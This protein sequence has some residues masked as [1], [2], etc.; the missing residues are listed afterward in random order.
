MEEMNHMSIRKKRKRLYQ[1]TRKIIPVLAVCGA[2]ILPLLSFATE[3]FDK[4]IELRATTVA[5][6]EITAIEVGDSILIEV[7]VASTNDDELTEPFV[8]NTDQAEFILHL[9]DSFTYNEELTKQH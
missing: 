5:G 4:K 2:I 9:G 8:G 3:S 1:L 7:S 6:E